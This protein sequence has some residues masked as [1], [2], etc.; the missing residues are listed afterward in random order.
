[1]FSSRMSNLHPYVHGEQPQ[2]RVYIKLNANENPYPPAGE[3]R[4]AVQELLLK[5]QRR[6]LCILIQIH[7]L[8]ALPLP[9]C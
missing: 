3:V 9:I 6:F 7:M 8:F 4:A 5:I 1:M 2:D